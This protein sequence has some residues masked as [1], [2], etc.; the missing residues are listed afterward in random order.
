MTTRI[1][2]RTDPAGP[3][4]RRA[5]LL[6]AIVALTG[7]AAEAVGQDLTALQRTLEA[8]DYQ[9]YIPPRANWGPGFV[10]AGDVVDGMMK[11]VEAVCSNLYEDVG[12][13]EAAAI[14]LPDFKAEDKFSF[15][16]AIG[17]LRGLFGGKVD[18]SAVERDRKVEVRWHNLQEMS[19]P[20]MVGWLQNGEPRPITKPCR[21]A[22][23]D[24]K[25]KNWF[26]DR[27][28]VI[29]RAVAPETLVYDFTRAL[30]GDTAV[31]AQ[32]AETLKA[33]ARGKGQLVSETQLEIKQRL[34]IG[35]AAPVK[36]VDWVPTN[37]VSGEIVTVRGA[38]ENLTIGE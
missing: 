12:F 7:A 27:I 29:V 25:V 11:N 8:N 5:L 28:F 15:S 26:V 20:R 10:F 17:F 31:S 22:I 35:Y 38:R 3:L 13:P 36:I 9:L 33:E 19:Y 2:I 6:L 34:Y 30:S 21:A 23:E 1:T 16:L 37:L 14:V 32:F 24:L 18:L 4:R